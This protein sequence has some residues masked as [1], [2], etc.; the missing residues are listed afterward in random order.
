MSESI[1]PDSKNIQR[2]D[3]FPGYI[4]FDAK[5]QWVEYNLSEKSQ[6]TSLKISIKANECFEIITP[7]PNSPDFRI[8]WCTGFDHFRSHLIKAIQK[9]IIG[10]D[11]NRNSENTQQAYFLQRHLISHIRPTKSKPNS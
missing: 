4:T 11:K 10:D 1:S 8:E 3:C 9:L 7:I 6:A 2:S 5:N